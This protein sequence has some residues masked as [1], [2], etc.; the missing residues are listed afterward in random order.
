MSHESEQY[1]TNPQVQTALPIL[2]VKHTHSSLPAVLLPPGKP[3][4]DITLQSG[5]SCTVVQASGD[6]GELPLGLGV[7]VGTLMEGTEELVL[8]VCMGAE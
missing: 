6:R 3:P 7:D 4:C 2:G 5:L 1:L 8:F